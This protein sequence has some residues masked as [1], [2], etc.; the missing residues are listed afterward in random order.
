MPS[1]EE[2]F[3]KHV[4]LFALGLSLI[5][6]GQAPLS[7]SDTSNVLFGKSGYNPGAYPTGPSDEMTPGAYCDHPDEVRYPEQINYC[8]RNV[9]SSRKW[10]IIHKYDEAFGYNIANMNRDDFK[11]DHL[12]PLCFGGA[13]SD[14]NLW[15]QHKTVYAKTDIL[16]DTLCQL[17]TRGQVSQYTAVRL[18]LRAK[19][20]LATI[21]D[22][23]TEIHNIQSGKLQD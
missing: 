12:I 13:N 19:H 18:I 5:S 9:S 11:I 22:V 8:R 15:P 6:C 16:E 7:D 10:A 1:Y 20:D 4:L 23:E 17:L 3:M 14:T 21:P 2:D